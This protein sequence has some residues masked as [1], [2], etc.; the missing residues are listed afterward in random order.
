M[1][2]GNSLALMY[3]TMTTVYPVC[4]DEGYVCCGAWRVVAAPPSHAFNL[5]RSFQTSIFHTITH[6]VATADKMLVTLYAMSLLQS[7][8]HVNHVLP[9]P[10]TDLGLF[11]NY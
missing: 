5:A 4:S 2:V 10:L 6:H 11:I 9:I 7:V 1:E 3:F 8:P